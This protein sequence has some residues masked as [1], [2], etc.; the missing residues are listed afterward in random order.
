MAVN[1]FRDFAVNLAIFEVWSDLF[2]FV[3][4]I[5]V[6][7]YEFETAKRRNGKS[8]YYDKS[9]LKQLDCER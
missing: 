6:K 5:F 7:P 9:M 4:M 3:A 8:V 2:Q 1:G